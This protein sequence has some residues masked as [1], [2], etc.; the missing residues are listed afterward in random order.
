L[1]PALAQ[2]VKDLPGSVAV[3]HEELFG[4]F[5]LQGARRELPGCQQGGDLVGYVA[6]DQR[7]GRQVHRDGE[8]L[9]ARVPDGGLVQ[10][11]GQHQLGEGGHQA[12]FLDQAQE[13][14]GIQQ[15]ADRMIPAHQRLDPTDGAGVQVDLGLV[16]QAQLVFGQG[17]AQVLQGA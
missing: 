1:D 6:V 12:G 11:L 5:Q 9:A 17:S 7:A 15:A 13:A 16:V 4:D 2:S 8:R 14:R 3:G 10:R